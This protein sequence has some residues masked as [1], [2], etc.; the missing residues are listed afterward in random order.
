MAKHPEG[1]N[2]LHGSSATHVAN[3]AAFDEVWKQWSPP[4]SGAIKMASNEAP[5]LQLPTPAND[6][7]VHTGKTTDGKP[8]TVY[9]EPDYFSNGGK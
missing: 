5:V 6:L 7:K 4:A 8:F 9:E 1:D 2:L 3:A